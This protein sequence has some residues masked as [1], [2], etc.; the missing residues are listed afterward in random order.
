V[1]SDIVECCSRITA[2]L[3]DAAIAISCIASMIIMF[4]ESQEI[5]PE[6]KIEWKID[7]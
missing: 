5:Q 7:Y 4:N 1:P 6:T 3:L 2:S